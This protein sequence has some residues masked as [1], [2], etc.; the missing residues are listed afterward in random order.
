[1]SF[2]VYSVL[3]FI[4][5]GGLTV[6]IFETGLHG[7]RVAHVLSTKEL[8]EVSYKHHLL[9][10]NRTFEF[11]IVSFLLT[12]M[13]TMS[14]GV[15][16]PTGWV[17]DFLFVHIAVG[18]VCVLI[19]FLARFWLTGVRYPAIHHK[20]VQVGLVGYLF[21]VFPTGVFFYIDV[22]ERVLLKTH[23]I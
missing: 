22:F 5:V 9:W 2:I 10:A 21:F 15:G 16:F 23:L 6:S 20:I 12:R 13:V 11:G 1:V 14:A 18:V 8:P 7:F 19:Y 3:W 4:A 17:R